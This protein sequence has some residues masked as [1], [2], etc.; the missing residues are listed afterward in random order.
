MIEL[1]IAL[2]VGAAANRAGAKWV[3]SL[4]E[5]SPFKRPGAVIFG[6]GGPGPVKPK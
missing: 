6:G 4:P 1:L 2:I 5:D 3:R